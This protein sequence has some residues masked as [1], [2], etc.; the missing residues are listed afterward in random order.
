MKGLAM[1]GL[2]MNDLAKTVAG[3]IQPVR[4]FDDGSADGLRNHRRRVPLRGMTW[5][6]RAVTDTDRQTR[7]IARLLAQAPRSG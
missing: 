1:K 5:G 7:L 2:A 6:V 3:L 4:T